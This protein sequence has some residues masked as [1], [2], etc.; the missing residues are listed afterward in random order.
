MELET[1]TQTVPEQ[2]P[3]INHRA[4]AHGAPD[5]QGDLGAGGAGRDRERW[6][7]NEPEPPHDGGLVVALWGLAALIAEVEVL[8]WVFAR[9]Y[10]H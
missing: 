10:E 4:R 8:W 1:M 6:T 5:P 7:R 3:V 2:K 9:M